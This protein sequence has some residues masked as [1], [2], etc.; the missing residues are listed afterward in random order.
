MDRMAPEPPVPV[1]LVGTVL[2]M[3]VALVIVKVRAARSVR[4]RERKANGERPG[5]PPRG[6]LPSDPA[7]ALA[8]LK[9][10]SGPAEARS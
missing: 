5:S 6:D 2:L 10:S 3:L 7:E 1:P 4:D 9:S 8:R